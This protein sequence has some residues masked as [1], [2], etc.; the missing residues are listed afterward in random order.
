MSKIRI[1][2]MFG[3][4]I[5]YGGQESVVYNMLSVLDLKNDF[6]VSLFT[7][8]YVDNE[9]LIKL[10]KNNKGKIFHFDLKFKTG[11]NRFKLKSYIYDFFKNNN[12]QFDIV[13]IH[14]GSILTMLVF[15]MCAKK[16]NI[17]KVIVHAHNA[18]I[19]NDL[20]YKFYR[21]FICLFLKK[22][23]D[24]FLGCSIKAINWRWSN[25][26]SKKGILINNGIDINR[27]KYH[28]TYNISLRQ[29][30]SLNN[31]F[32]IGSV[33]RFT[34]E[35]NHKFMIEVIELLQKRSKDFVLM[36]I[37][38]GMLMNEI[39]NIVHIKNLDE[40]VIF[41][42]NTE[43]IYKYYSAFDCFILPSYYEGMPVTVIEAQCARVPVIISKNVT[44]DVKISN[45]TFFLDIANPVIW[46]S[47]IIQIKKDIEQ[48]KNYKNNIKVDTKKFDRAITFK[49][50]S[51]IY[52]I[53]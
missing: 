3:E 8:Y 44:I 45:K 40:R 52:R 42:D 17:K 53:N 32:I 26:I 21:F 9:K 7:P 50:I 15:A 25:E 41:I 24:Y 28:K 46:A 39:K 11:D 1:L 47:K 36:L 20:I 16:N 34:S 18:G 27:Y 31:K 43:Y 35:K 2:E 23:V 6:N 4:P 29:K 30:Y 49:K 12:K 5:T 33:A 10:I 19:K 38:K 13:H 37:G 22:Y 14:T 51:D 48:D